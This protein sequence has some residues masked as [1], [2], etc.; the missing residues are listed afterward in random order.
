MRY[1]RLAT[2]QE[3]ADEASRLLPLM[4]DSE[5]RIDLSLTFPINFK[6]LS[7]EFFVY[8]SV[9]DF[10]FLPIVFMVLLLCQMRLDRKDDQAQNHML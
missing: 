1:N 8:C 10:H 4:V 3:E 9:F 2:C 5:V 7:K 6:R